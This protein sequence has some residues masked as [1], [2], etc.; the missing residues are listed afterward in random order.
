MSEQRIKELE[1]ELE[2]LKAKLYCD[3]CGKKFDIDLMKKKH[4]KQSKICQTASKLPVVGDP[5]KETLKNLHGCVLY[6]KE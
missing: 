2:A 3:I 4:Q 5:E 1:A 6:D